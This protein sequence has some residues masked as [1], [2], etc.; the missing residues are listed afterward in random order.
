MNHRY[1]GSVEEQRGLVQVH[2]LDANVDG[3]MSKFDDETNIKEVA[4]SSEGCQKIAVHLIAL[5][6]QCQK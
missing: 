6:I 3:S 5:L 2:E 4:D 1:P